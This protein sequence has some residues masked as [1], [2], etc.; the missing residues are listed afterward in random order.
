MNTLPDITFANDLIAR[1]REIIRYLR[2]SPKA[3]SLG[4]AAVMAAGVAFLV[5]SD[6]AKQLGELIFKDDWLNICGYTSS[7]LFV[8]SVL[9]FAS[10]CLLLWKELTPPPETK[11]IV[12]PTALKGP[13]AFGPH[14]IELFRRLGRETETATLLNWIL[15]EQIGLIV[16]KGASGAG[17]T[18][19]LRAGLPGLLL[20]QSPPIEYHYWEAVP[21]QAATGLLNAVKA[22]WLVTNGTL[23]PEKLSDLGTSDQHDVRR[24][25]VLDQ[26]EQISPNKS[27]HKSIFRL[28]KNVA[29]TAKPPHKITYIV[30]FRADYASNWFDFQYDQLAGRAPTM[31]SLRLFN[32]NQAK[33]IIAVIA[34]VAKFTMDIKLVDDHYAAGSQRA[35]AGQDNQ[36]PSEGRLSGRRRGHWF[37]GGLYVEPIRAVSLR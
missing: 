31:M 13:M 22:G 4:C 33:D 27:A 18:S 26:F 11:D 32:E 9:L 14:D 34:D 8:L 21:D 36:A 23:V 16:I 28:L 2:R 35:C 37:A 1:L 25:I 19:L 20:K 7:A 12:R 5:R 3:T 30:L 15:D 24:V 6:Q 29:L 17:K 10:T